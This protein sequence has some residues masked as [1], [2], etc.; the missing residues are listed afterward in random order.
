MVRLVYL[1]VIRVFG[2][3]GLLAPGDKALMVKMLALRHEV[4]VL[5]RQVRGR[6]RWSWPDRAVLAALAQLLPRAVRAHRIVSRRRC[7]PGIA[8]WCVDVGRTP[9]VGAGGRS[10]TRSVDW[11]CGWRGTIPRWGCRRIQGELGWLG[12][13][14]GVGDDPADPRSWS[15][16]PAPRRWTPAARHGV[17]F[18]RAVVNSKYASC[19]GPHD[20]AS[21]V[22]LTHGNTDGHPGAGFTLVWAGQATAQAVDRQGVPLNWSLRRRARCRHRP[23]LAPSASIT[24]YV[25]RPRSC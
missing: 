15:D 13:R 20:D 17:E 14:V 25:R 9:T 10:V 5:R 24:C 22:V 4:A 7:W 21:I 18:D 12:H 6:A 19:G 11:C 3:L 16:R 8:G 23:T 2:G 1:M